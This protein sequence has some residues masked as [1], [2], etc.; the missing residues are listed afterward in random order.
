MMY[1]PTAGLAST[2]GPDLATRLDRIESRDEIRGLKA[3]Y[4]QGLDDRLRGAVADLFW[5]DAIWE[6]LPDRPLEGDAP[7]KAGS[8]I[9]GRGAIA[10]SFVAAAVNMSFTAHFL[11][12]ENITV[13]GDRAVGRWKLLQA[14]NAG[15]DRAFW[16]AGAYVDDFERRD[17]I[18]KFSH[19]RLALDFRTPFDEG[20]LVNRLWEPAS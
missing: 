1:G 6:S 16:Q 13:D 17:G 10:E 14:C 4:M 15:R 7:T 11:T 9:V 2:A 5:E 20:W 8:Q 19:L 12:N 3:A 18:W